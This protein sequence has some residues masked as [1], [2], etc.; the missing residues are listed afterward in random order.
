MNFNEL[1]SL[2]KEIESD[3][4]ITDE[5]CSQKILHV[6]NLFQRYLSIYIREAQLLKTLKLDLVKIES[7][8]F[9]FYKEEYERSLNKGE[10][11]YYVS[12]DEKYLEK[13]RSLDLQESICNFLEMTVQNF[14]SLPFNL[15]SYV[16]LRTFLGGGN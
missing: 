7:E 5:N 1:N 13:K 16:Q 15:R 10:I 4:L 8:K 14:K 12:L 9:K 3:L 11:E 2:K 6:P